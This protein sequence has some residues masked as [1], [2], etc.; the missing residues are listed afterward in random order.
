[1]EV[2]NCW[3]RNNIASG[4]GAGILV[5]SNSHPRIINCEVSENVQTSLG[6][7]KGGGGIAITGSTPSPASVEIENC[8]IAS[9]FESLRAV[10]EA[11]RHDPHLG[12]GEVE[13][14][15]A[16]LLIDEVNRYIELPPCRYHLSPN[17]NAPLFLNT[18]GAWTH[19]PAI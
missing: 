19:R 1:M 2:S 12:A 5:N 11:G 9:N 16:R 7:G 18:V 10:Y 3:V 13:H 8:L 14:Y 17:F 6:F 4:L 15:V